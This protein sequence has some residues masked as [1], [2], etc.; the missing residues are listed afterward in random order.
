MRLA[1]EGEK[2]FNS[3]KQAFDSEGF[4]QICCPRETLHDTRHICGVLRRDQDRRK[5]FSRFTLP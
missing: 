5:T 4:F 1:V 2:I 3:F